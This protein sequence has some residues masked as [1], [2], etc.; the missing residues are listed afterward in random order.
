VIN[1]RLETENNCK[2]PEHL[3]KFF[4]HLLHLLKAIVN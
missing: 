3:A 1:Y 4:D 2:S